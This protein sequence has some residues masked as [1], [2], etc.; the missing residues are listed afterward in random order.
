MAG[1]AARRKRIML[2]ELNPDAFIGV[3]ADASRGRAAEHGWLAAVAP[4]AFDLF[5]GAGLALIGGCAC[6]GA[7]ECPPRVFDSNAM[8]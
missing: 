8:P 7:R 6:V 2:G 1:L 3:A 5:L 4:K